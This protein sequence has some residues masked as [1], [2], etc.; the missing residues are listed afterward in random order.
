MAVGVRRYNDY[1][2]SRIPRFVISPSLVSPMND[3]VARLKMSV[4]LV[5]V[6]IP[7]DLDL[8]F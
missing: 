3:S 7:I 5:Q 8:E 1:S 2:E 6:S 4:A